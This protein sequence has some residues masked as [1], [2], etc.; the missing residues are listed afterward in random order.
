MIHSYSSQPLLQSLRYLSLYAGDYMTPCYATYLEPF[1]RI[2]H[3]ESVQVLYFD[4][5]NT[6]TWT[7]ELSSCDIS[8]LSF[9]Y[10]CITCSLLCQMFVY[11][12]AVKSP[13]YE[14]SGHAATRPPSYRFNAPA[15]GVALRSLTKTLENLRDQ[16]SSVRCGANDS[17]GAE[18][19][20]LLASI[21]SS[22]DTQHQPPYPHRARPRGIRRSAN[23]YS[24]LLA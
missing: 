13:T 3:L 11:C 1:F 22:Q 23:G 4:G 9:N 2:D 19:S 7:F 20:W 15:M 24:T 6:R 12:R 5:S 17:C 18:Q 8:T 10:S 21:P 16:H 14:N